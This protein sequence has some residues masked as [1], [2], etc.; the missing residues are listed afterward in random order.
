MG[1]P[2]SSHAMTK[3][4]SFQSFVQRPKSQ[5]IKMIGPETSEKRAGQPELHRTM[6]G[7]LFQLKGPR[8]FPNNQWQSRP[9]DTS[10][11]IHLLTSSSLFISRDSQCEGLSTAISSSPR[12][13]KRLS[14]ILV[15]A[16]QVLTPS[17]IKQSKSSPP[18]SIPPKPRIQKHLSIIVS[19]GQ[20]GKIVK[21]TPERD[22]DFTVYLFLRR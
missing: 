9:H 8:L 15:R 12:L 20:V 5:P 21:L 1:Q 10:H 19:I 18:N 6:Y 7:P 13:K 4:S 14:L 16:S 22:R 11:P 2:S 3:P 17:S